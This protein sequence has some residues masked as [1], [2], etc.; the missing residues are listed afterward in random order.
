MSRHARLVLPALVALAAACSAGSDAAE[1]T[2]AATPVTAVATP[3]DTSPLR[4]DEVEVTGIAMRLPPGHVIRTTSGGA[5]FQMLAIAPAADSTA[6]LVEF[7]LGDRPQFDVSNTRQSMINGLV[8]RDRVAK[9]AEERWS[10][11]M[12]IELPRTS[13][14]GVLPTR[15]HLFYN[16]LAKSDA[17]RADSVLA[18]IRC[19]L[20]SPAPAAKPGA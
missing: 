10:R 15:M 5:D 12:L 17:E 19:C 18:S 16:R 3:I 11:E 7:Y 13:A 20:R 2:G 8:A 14:A 1:D 9:L 6:A 4:P